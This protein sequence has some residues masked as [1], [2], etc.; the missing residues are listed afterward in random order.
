L[1]I[2]DNGQY[3]IGGAQGVSTTYEKGSVAEQQNF[4]S[5]DNA[6]VANSNLYTVDEFNQ[7]IDKYVAAHPEEQ[8][9][10]KPGDSKPDDNQNQN[11]SGNGSTDTNKPGDNG[12]AN[13]TG[14]TG[15]ANGQTSQAKPVYRLYK[16]G[17]VEHLYSASANEIKALVRKGWRNEG[18][19][20][21][22]TSGSPQHLRPI[23]REYNPRTQRH[24]WTSDW[25]EDKALINKHGWKG[26]GV[27]WYSDM[28]GTVDVYRLSN[29]RTGEH[30]FS[31][32]Q[33]ECRVLVS[34]GW[35][36]EGVSFKGL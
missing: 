9:S 3:S 7:L 30:L 23:L 31:T 32:S 8:Q 11:N 28:D 4:S 1:N 10:S 27:A 17:A 21:Q 34:R 22:A 36:N 35:R 13:N 20:F 12:S 25:L 16:P 5:Q 15:S 24:N 29:P 2:V 18:V 6:L 26:E 33:N 19:V 14:N